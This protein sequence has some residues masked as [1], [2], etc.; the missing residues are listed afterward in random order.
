MGLSVAFDLTTLEV[1][2]LTIKSSSRCLN[3]G[4]AI[5]SVEDMN[6]LFDGIPL[7]RMSISMTLNRA[8]IPVLAC[9]IASGLNQGCPLEKLTGAIQNDILKEFMVKIFIF[10]PEPSMRI[11]ADMSEFTSKKMPKFNSISRNWL[12]YAGGWS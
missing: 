7:E 6:K 3:A 4:V 10:P 1:M 2:T 11:V 12:S 9:F 5:D 8:V